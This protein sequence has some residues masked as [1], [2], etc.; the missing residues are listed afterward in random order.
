MTNPVLRKLGSPKL[1]A[2]DI[3]DLLQR[4]IGDG[5]NESHCKD[6]CEALRRIRNEET[7]AVVQLTAV[8]S[9]TC[10]NYCEVV[11]QVIEVLRSNPALRNK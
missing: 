2:R 6:A 9:R 7:R 4:H 5:S 1:S 3:A 10:N 8:I 11:K